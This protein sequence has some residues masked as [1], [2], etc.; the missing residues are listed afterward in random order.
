MLHA[1]EELARRSV[2]HLG[3]QQVPLGGAGP[4]VAHGNEAPRVGGFDPQV[5]DGSSGLRLSLV[6]GGEVLEERP[7]KGREVTVGTLEKRSEGDGVQDPEVSNG[8]ADLV[9]GPPGGAAPGRRG[10]A[11]WGPW[12]AGG[13]D[14][15]KLPG[16]IAL[17]AEHEDAQGDAQEGGDQREAEAQLTQP[18]IG[19]GA[20]HGR[21][22]AGCGVYPRSRWRVAVLATAAQTPPTAVG[23][24]GP[25]RP[26]SS[27]GPS[28]P[29]RSARGAGVAGAGV[30]GA[31][32]VGLGGR[33]R[34][35]DGPTRPARSP[36]L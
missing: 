13:L 26:T 6:Q 7:G 34:S 30:V 1:F 8:V 12:G 28:R 18:G 35:S 23:C 10:D 21:G 3:D 16:D 27:P 24:E 33:S 14:G 15:L 25:V 29:H 11:R 20:I 2:L 17:P 36:G 4:S 31:G 32:V 9:T 5:I 19:G 22:G